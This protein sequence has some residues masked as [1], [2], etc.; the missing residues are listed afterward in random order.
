MRAGQQQSDD[1]SL[2][3]LPQTKD[4]NSENQTKN[5]TDFLN[6]NIL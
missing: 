6:V 1:I 4:V 5:F 2:L 3:F